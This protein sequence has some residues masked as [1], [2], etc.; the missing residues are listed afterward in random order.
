M[1]RRSSLAECSMT[2]LNVKVF[3]IER[4]AIKD[5]PGIR[6]VVFMQGC[7]LHCPWCSNPESQ[8]FTSVLRY[9]GSKCLHCGACAAVCPQSA[10]TLEGGSVR[11]DRSSCMLCGACVENCQ[12]AAL[13][14]T[15]KMMSVREV[16][17]VVLRDK[18]YYEH[19]G[20][21]VTFSGGEALSQPE[22]LLAMLESCREHGVH[23]AVETTADAPFEVISRMEPFT[24]L[25]L[26][27][28]KHT[29]GARLRQVTGAS[30]ELIFSNI[31]ALSRSCSRKIRLRMPCIPG[32]NMERE[33][34]MK[35]FDFAGKNGITGIDLLPYHALGAGKYRQLGLDYGYDNTSAP[36]R[37]ELESYAA[38]GIS[39]G[40]DIRIL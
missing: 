35:A 10:V 33:H 26:I 23:T 31:E 17:D 4:F 28:I 22:A 1:S 5:G 13:K 29:D 8:P 20:G 37:M 38:A 24:D 14:I 11:I 39:M 30:A 12:G 27:D 18:D 6:S 16:V 2:D 21:G 9:L 7:P 25:F 32:F 15:P 36:D 3:D 19:S 40:L 34:F